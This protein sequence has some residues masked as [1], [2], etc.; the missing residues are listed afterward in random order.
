MAA[1]KAGTRASAPT[2][3]AAATKPRILSRPNGIMKAVAVSPALRKFLGVPEVSRTDAVKKIWE[4]IKLNNLQFSAT[5]DDLVLVLLH[6]NITVQLGKELIG[7]HYAVAKDPTLYNIKALQG[8][9]KKSYFQ[10]GI[11]WPDFIRGILFQLLFLVDERI[12]VG[13]LPER[14]DVKV[15]ET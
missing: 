4:Y 6:Y 13:L 14:L 3:S 1:A 10:T 11:L 12:V 2:A 5:V 9:V 7:F 15:E 8:P